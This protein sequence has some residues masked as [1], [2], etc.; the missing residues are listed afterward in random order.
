MR[1]PSLRAAEALAW[2]GDIATATFLAV[3]AYGLWIA[4]P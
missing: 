3:L 2:A 1:A 4:T